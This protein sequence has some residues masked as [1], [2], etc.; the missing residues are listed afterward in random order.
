MIE[1]ADEYPIDALPCGFYGYTQR[2]YS[3]SNNPSPYPK[4]KTK[5]YYPGEV[6]ANPP[7]DSPYGGSN[8][9]TS[10]G[11][12]IRR[13]YLGF[14][15]TEYG[16]DESFLMYKGKQNPQSGWELATDSIPWNVLSKGFHMDSGATVVTIGN[17]YETSGQTAFECGVDTFIADPE[18]QENPYYI[19]IQENTQ[20]VLLAD[21]M[22]GIFITNPELTQID[23]N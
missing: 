18:T 7:F 17:I 4:F 6:I 2:Q 20:Y 1:L 11:N 23:F 16:I 8:A 15:T 12:V 19:Y 9:V 10:P 5:Y 13:S 14:S 22:V 3:S 21:L